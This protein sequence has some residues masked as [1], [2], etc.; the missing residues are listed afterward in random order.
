MGTG[1]S[2]TAVAAKQRSI[3][4]RSPFP[5][6]PSSL[7]TASPPLPPSLSPQPVTRLERKGD[8]PGNTAGDG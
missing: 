7:F 4:P 6:A 1:S 8:H 5:G 3:I 2:E